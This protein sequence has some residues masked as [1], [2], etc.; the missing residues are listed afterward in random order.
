M[1][2]IIC[3]IAI[4]G[5]HALTLLSTNAIDLLISLLY[6]GI[7]QRHL[8]LIFFTDLRVPINRQRTIQR[9]RPFKSDCVQMC[10]QYNYE[11]ILR[12]K[13]QELCII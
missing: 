13:Y 3:I 12:L 6:Q 4:Y 11:Y 2:H 5:K 9:R 1:S 8:F 7:V 10:D